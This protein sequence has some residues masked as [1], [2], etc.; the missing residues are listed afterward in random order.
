MRAVWSVCRVGLWHRAQEQI[1]TEL[2]AGWGVQIQS[3]M[4]G[5]FSLGGMNEAERAGPTYS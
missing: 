3:K 2:E 4:P 1:N 5:L